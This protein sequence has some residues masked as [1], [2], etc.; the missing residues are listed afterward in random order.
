MIRGHLK[1]LALAA[2]KEKPLSGYD[3]MAQL[4]ACLCSKPSP[5]S[6]YPLLSELEA[7]GFISVKADGR[8]KVYRLTARGEKELKE[9]AS[10]R[11]RLFSQMSESAK[12]FSMLTGDDMDFFEHIAGSLQKGELPFKEVAPEMARFRRAMG[13]IA[14]Q[15]ILARRG[16]RVHAA[17]GRLNT[18]LESILAEHKKGCGSLGCDCGS[19]DNPRPAKG[20]KRS[21]S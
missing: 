2:L 15:G 4:G 16:D 18:E 21:I 5:G 10:L 9:L 14:S 7:A 11:E 3:L 12:I 1:H 17:I 19:V 6:V 20:K 8:K 13:K